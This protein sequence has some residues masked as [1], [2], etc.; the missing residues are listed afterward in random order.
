M[1]IEPNGD[2]YPCVFFPHEKEVKLGNIRDDVE[3]IWTNNPLLMKLRDKDAL[4]GHCGVCDSRYIC[5]GCRA[6]A[7]NYFHDVTYPDPGCEK[8]KNAWD[9]IIEKES[10]EYLA[11]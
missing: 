4:L 1:S 11:K 7:Y 8:N 9:K 2:I 3:N 10:S 5:G 6:R